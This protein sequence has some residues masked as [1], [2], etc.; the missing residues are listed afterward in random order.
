VRVAEGGGALAL[1]VWALP[2]EAVGAFLAG[3][4]APLCIGTIRLSDGEAVQ[5]FLCEA[6]AAEGAEDVTGH[7]GWRAYLASA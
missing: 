6:V 2:R 1:E 3:V 7:G 4:P 5:G